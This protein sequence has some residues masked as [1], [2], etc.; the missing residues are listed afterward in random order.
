M[1][2]YISSIAKTFDISLH[3]PASGAT[4]YFLWR[5]HLFPIT[6]GDPV[7]CVVKSMK[8]HGCAVVWLASFGSQ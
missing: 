7:E 1:C 5:P 2:D 4:S 3:N 6:D 8:N